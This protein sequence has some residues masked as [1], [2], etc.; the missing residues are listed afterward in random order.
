MDPFKLVGAFGIISISIGILLKKRKTQDF[1]YI[2]G[3][4]C[5]ESYSIHIGDMIFIIL[6][7]IFTGT[8]AYD[9]YKAG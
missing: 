6:Q 5:L 9:F 4:L 3:G 8:A 1:F 2:I 7:M